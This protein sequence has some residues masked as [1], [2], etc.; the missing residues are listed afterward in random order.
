MKTLLTISALIVLLVLFGCSR[1]PAAQACVAG[2]G[3]ICPSD[4]QLREVKEMQAIDAS[5]QKRLKQFQD[6]NAEP[7]IRYN[8]LLKTVSD[9]RPKGYD[10]DTQKSRWVKT[11][12]PVANSSP[13]PS[14]AIPQTSSIP[15]Q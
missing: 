4:I 12:A 5:F 10:W 1:K 7:R 3:E 9:E 15:A 8:G 14:P 11:P 13:A 6:D 2:P